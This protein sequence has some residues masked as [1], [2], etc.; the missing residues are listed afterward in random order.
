MT[1]DREYAHEIY[2]HPGE[3]DTRPLAVDVPYLYARALGYEPSESWH[4]ALTSDDITL[5]R[6]AMN[7]TMLLL[8]AREIA[9]IADALAQGLA[10]DE[11]WKWAEERAN[12]ESGE[13]IWERAVHYGVNPEAIKPYSLGA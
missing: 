1:E 5:R 10:G 4:D 13:W 7:R 11:A 9:L 3:D 6:L 8:A 2:P 12:E